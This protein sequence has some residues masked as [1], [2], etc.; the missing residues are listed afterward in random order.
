LE[1]YDD[2]G[3]LIPEPNAPW[4]VGDGVNHGEID[5][6]SDKIKPNH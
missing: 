1:C 6:E 2:E 5:F 4:T 3:N